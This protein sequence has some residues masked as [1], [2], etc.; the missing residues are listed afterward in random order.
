MGYTKRSSSTP[1][2]IRVLYQ[3][4]LLLLVPIGFGWLYFRDDKKKREKAIEVDS[5][6]QIKVWGGREILDGEGYAQ[7]EEYMRP[8]L[9]ENEMYK[10]DLP[11]T[12]IRSEV[13][14]ERCI[15]CNGYGVKKN[16]KGNE[17][18]CPTCDGTGMMLIVR[19]ADG[20]YEI[21]RRGTADTGPR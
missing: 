14:K 11:Q 7:L 2:I 18:V 16:S 6:K 9:S 8:Y 1:S 20:M 12:A 13:K 17:Y 21:T 10:K 4:A 15:K 19:R 3:V 5:S